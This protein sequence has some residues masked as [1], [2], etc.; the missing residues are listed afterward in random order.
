MLMSSNST[1]VSP[2]SQT[3]GS[4]GSFF[5]FGRKKP[6][7]K[8]DY[9]YDSSVVSTTSQATV[10]ILFVVGTSMTCT[11]YSDLA[12]NCVSGQKTVWVTVDNNPGNMVKLDAGL[13][14]EAFNDIKANITER[15]GDTA[16]SSAAIFV[17]GHSAGGY[18]A[19]AA[20]Q[21]NGGD[22]NFKPIGCV[23]ADP[24]NKTKLP[25]LKIE[26]QTFAMGFTVETCFVTPVDAGLA[27][28]NITSNQKDRVMMQMINPRDRGNQITHCIFATDGCTACPAHQ[29][30]DWTRPVMGKFCILFVDSVV[31]G[32]RTTKAQYVDA[33]GDNSSLVNVFFGDEVATV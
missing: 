22:Y 25:T 9:Y 1:I 2:G 21:V 23:A 7:Y 8:Y 15:L 28:Y 5:G 16:S 26:C 29:A 31:K 24:W 27:A 4:S 10:V 30:G 18:S 6:H 33:T 32:K 12:G 20:M 19:I 17:G 3:I 11:A 14:A 13:T